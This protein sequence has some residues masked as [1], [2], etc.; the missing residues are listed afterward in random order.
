M[1]RIGTGFGYWGASAADDYDYGKVLAV[2][3]SYRW[4]KY[5]RSSFVF[6]TCC[7]QNYFYHSACY[8]FATQSRV[9]SSQVLFLT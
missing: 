1:L 3:F 2:Q 9:L 4:V 5:R 6:N 8:M 7:N